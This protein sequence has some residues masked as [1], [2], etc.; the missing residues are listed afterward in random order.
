MPFPR[1]LL[2]S[3]EEVVLDTRPHWI[4]LVGPVA[5]GVLLL[6][7]LS[8]GLASV[9]GGGTNSVLRW[10]IVIVVLIVAV[11]YPIRRFVQWATSRFVVTNQRLIHRSGLVA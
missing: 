11:A 7:A 10:I 4:A 6:V 5:V 3:G 8:W 1:K 9:H 2:T